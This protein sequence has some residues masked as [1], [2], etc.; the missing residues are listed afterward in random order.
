MTPHYI[1]AHDGV[2]K[3]ENLFAFM[4]QEVKKAPAW[5]ERHHLHA[6]AAR[7]FLSLP[8]FSPQQDTIEP[9]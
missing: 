1:P 4:N 2:E 3:Y 5:L 6:L 9:L 8:E 7:P